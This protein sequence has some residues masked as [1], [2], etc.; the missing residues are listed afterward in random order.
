VIGHYLA[1]GG[2]WRAAVWGAVSLGVAV[3]V[4]LPFARALERRRITASKG[5]DSAR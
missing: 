2:D 1:T 3:L 5:P 4:Y